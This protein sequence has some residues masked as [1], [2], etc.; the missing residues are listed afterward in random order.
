MIHILSSKHQTYKS[1]LLHKA[2]STAPLEASGPSPG[3]SAYKTE[4]IFTTVSRKI[5]S[6]ELWLLLI[7]SRRKEFFHAKSPDHSPVLWYYP[8][9]R[10][11]RRHQ[12]IKVRQWRKPHWN[13]YMPRGTGSRPS[14]YRVRNCHYCQGWKGELGENQTTQEHEGE[15]ET[16]LFD[17]WSLK[18]NVIKYYLVEK[19]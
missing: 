11:Q 2:Q 4:E 3:L 15:E 7:R 6:V 5:S 16:N 17:K 9:A 10:C 14:I 12:T 8:I 19:N 13:W 18:Y 1:F